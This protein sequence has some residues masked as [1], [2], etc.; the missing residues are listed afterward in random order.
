MMGADRVKNL[1]DAVERLRPIAQAYNDF[2]LNRH[3][4]FEFANTSI[5]VHW[6]KHHFMH[7]TGLRCDVP[8]QMRNSYRRRHL[9][10]PSG[11]EIFY[12]FLLRNSFG[13]PEIKAG[14]NLEIINLKLA[15]LEQL[16]RMPESVEYIAE[17]GNSKY[18]FFLGAENW[19][20]GVTCTDEP[21]IDSDA[22]V[23]APRT[24]QAR[25]V[26]STNITKTG[27]KPIPIID[28]RIIPRL[29]EN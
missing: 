2:F 29:N 10:V 17:S 12:D 19:C 24:A 25:S 26:L 23:H 14:H 15:A 9:Q 16:I 21:S 1:S 4:I 8:L 7:L 3:Y 27:T 20:L 28:T 13:K 5:D 22:K 11:S 6:L 18:D